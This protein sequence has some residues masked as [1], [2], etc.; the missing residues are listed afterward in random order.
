MAETIIA[1]KCKDFVMVAGAGLGAFYYIKITDDEDKLTQL[2]SHKLVACAGENGPR[3]NFVEYIKANMALNKVRRHGRPMSTPSTAN[4]MRQ[5]LA[6]ALRSEDGAYLANCLLA[7]YDSPSS[8]YDETPAEAHLYY[9]DYLGTLQSVPYGCHGYGTT[10]VVA[11]LDRLWRPDLTPQEGVDLMQK[12][13]DEV[14]KRI[15][16]ANNKFFCR[17]ITANG[18]EPV[19]SVN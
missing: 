14:K 10:F 8:E 5:A 2:D 4:F 9:L 11:M 13:C 12:C 7:G 15:I 16:F 18:V 6:Q 1:F 17:V 19:P 3:V